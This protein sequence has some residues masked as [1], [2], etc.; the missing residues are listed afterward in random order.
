MKRTEVVVLGLGIIGLLTVRRLQ[1][2]GHSP[3]VV[4]S[5]NPRSSTSAAAG[6]IMLQTFPFSPDSAEYGRRLT[7]MKKSLEFFRSYKG[8]RYIGKLNHVELFR[9][10]VVEGQVPMEWLLGGP[11]GVAPAVVNLGAPVRGFQQYTRFEVPYFNTLELLESLYLDCLAGGATVEYRRLGAG[12]VED[13]PADVIFNCLGFGAQEVF[14]DYELIP[15]FGQAIRY[16]PLR[17]EFGLGMGDFFALSSSYALYVGSPF[18]FGESRIGPKLEHYERLQEFAVYG[19]AELSREVGIDLRGEV[20]G[21]ALET[22]S[23]IRPFRPSGAC[24][25]RE[26]VGGRVVVHNYGHGAHGWA[27]GWGAVLDAV[28]LWSDGADD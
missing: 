19:I 6:G 12:A 20:P 22:V 14:G 3:V 15:V 9:D 25:E 24:V 18:V 8:G 17:L 2:L 1:E 7:W 5:A 4:A 28:G 21:E 27:A 23:G 26:E 10:G 16:P 13:L 11:D